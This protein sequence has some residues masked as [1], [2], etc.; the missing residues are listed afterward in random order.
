MALSTHD[1][2][3]LLRKRARRRLVGAI[4]MVSLSTA[5]LWNVVDALPEQ[6]MKP[7]AVDITGLQMASQPAA[8]PVVAS[9]PVAASQPVTDLLATLPPDEPVQAS[10]PV[11]PPPAVVANPAPSPA[12]VPPPV[13][14]QAEPKPPV[15]K[16][17]PAPV[18]KPEPKPEPKPA[19]KPEAKPQPKPETK[20]LAKPEPK[21]ETK[22]VAKET[23]PREEK[24]AADP[25]A[26]LEGRETHAEPAKPPKEQRSTETEAKP[27]DGGKKFNIQLAALSDPQKVDALRDRLAAAGV[28]ARFSKV[29]TSKGEV[30][31]VRVGPF[32]SREEADAAMRRLS[33]AGVTG[34]VVGAE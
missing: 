19:P 15:A 17:E 32:K 22:P 31:R 12:V 18:P 21:A 34:I 33:K 6:A 27:A 26:I 5:V 20:P 23:K 7:E 25:M 28:A 10:V 13:P 29:Q 30:T 24:K 11:A 1:E 2:L 16:P 8:A 14:K 9:A 3:L 4:V